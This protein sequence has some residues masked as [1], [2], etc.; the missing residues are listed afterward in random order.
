M[1]GIARHSSSLM[2][3][4]NSKGPVRP[5]EDA[6]P[7]TPN[8]EAQPGVVVSR[9]ETMIG[10]LLESAAKAEELVLDFASSPYS[11]HGKG[12]IR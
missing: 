1:Q 11:R 9:I 7:I 12:G 3:P 8:T 10:S 6:T 4:T 2:S 5:A